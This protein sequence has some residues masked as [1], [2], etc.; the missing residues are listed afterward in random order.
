MLLQDSERLFK[1]SEDNVEEGVYYWVLHLQE[2]NFND[3]RD[4]NDLSKMLSYKEKIVKITL[5]NESVKYK[6]LD[7][8]S[9]VFDYPPLAQT[10]RLCFTDKRF[11]R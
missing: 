4:K 6:Y 3:S 7:G 10:S 1:Y 2:F 11:I 5:E 8:K 9:L